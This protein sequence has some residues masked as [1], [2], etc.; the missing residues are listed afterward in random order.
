MNIN[1]LQWVEMDTVSKIDTYLQND[2]MK[3]DF[4]LFHVCKSFH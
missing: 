3:A 1:L 4:S 2:S